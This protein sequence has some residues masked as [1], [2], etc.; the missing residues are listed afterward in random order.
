MNKK[1][2]AIVALAVT[3][4]V[5]ISVFASKGENKKEVKTKETIKVTDRKGEVEVPKDP[6]RVIVLD[7]SS[8]D[9]MEF[10]GEEAIAVPK[11]NLPEYLSEYN[12]E[13]YEDLGSVKKFDIEKINELNPE[14]III[15][16][17]Q[18]EFYDEL[19]KIAPTILLGRDGNDHIKSLEYNVKVLGDIFGESQK[20]QEKVEQIN[21]RIL[22]ISDS[23]KNMNAN[24][25]VTMLDNGEISGFGKD[26]RFGM[27]YNELGF[28]EIDENLGE[29]S[30]GNSINSEYILNKNPQYLFVIDKAAVSASSDSNKDV[31]EN[32]LIKKT[33][34]FKNGKIVYL[35]TKAWYVGGPGI[36]ATEVMLSEIEQNITK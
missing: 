19:S 22:E 8:L 3:A 34:A 33:E 32:D 18:E 21:A 26:S 24:A 36:M 5:G 35:D 9:T 16:A 7:Y 12:D 28:K 23:V 4:V 29:S 13:K 14:L 27:I 2:L 17:R 6:E 25:L 10:L 31:I 1:V 15:E 11:S 20:A 30:H